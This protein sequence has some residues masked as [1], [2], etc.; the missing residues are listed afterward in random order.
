MPAVY[1]NSEICRHWN[2][3]HTKQQR[4]GKAATMR[5]LQRVIKLKRQGNVLKACFCFVTVSLSESYSEGRK[6]L[7]GRRILP[8]S[9]CAPFRRTMKS[10]TLPLPELC[11]TEIGS[12]EYRLR[13]CGVGGVLFVLAVRG[14]AG[15]PDL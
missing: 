11:K 5:S 6:H 1:L 2:L 8:W 9:N 13:G 3:G 10:A 7:V 4:A 15:P 14:E 12:K